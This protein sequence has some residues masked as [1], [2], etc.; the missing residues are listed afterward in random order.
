MIPIVIICFN[1]RKYVENMI[2]QIT[3]KNP[4]Y[5]ENLMIMDNASTDPD[6][7]DFLNTT[8]VQVSRNNMNMG[9]WV[10]G[11]YN[12]ETFKLLPKRYI[13]TD[14]DIELNKDMP[15]NFID[16]MVAVMDYTHAWIVG[17]AIREDGDLPYRG[18]LIF[19]K[20]SHMFDI[21]IDH[22]VYELY[23]GSIDTTFALRDHTGINLS[24]RMGGNFITRHL[25]W[26]KDDSVMTIAERYKLYSLS[27]K[28]LS[29]ISSI[30]LEYIENEYTKIT[31]ENGEIE[32][33]KK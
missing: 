8:T 10:N 4:N 25:P 9:P 29:G 3:A 11:Y 24:V 26:Y 23:N 33:V 15:A 30:M 12:P 7:L 19:S 20:K 22:P 1:N 28:R 21:R 32:F 14:A 13:L 5:V 27:D 2:R 31:N 17:F 6:T 18:D 16:D